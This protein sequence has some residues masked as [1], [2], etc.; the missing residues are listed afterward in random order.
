MKEEKQQTRAHMRTR[1]VANQQPGCDV[2]LIESFN[3]LKRAWISAGGENME[4]ERRGASLWTEWLNASAPKRQFILDDLSAAVRRRQQ[5][6]RWRDNPLFY[7]RDY[8]E[9][10][11]TD[12]NGAR[13]FPDEP[14]VI[15]KHN[16]VGG[17][18]T[19]REAELFKMTDVKPFNL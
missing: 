18:F 13:S 7:L 17:L 4:F 10:E 1:D 6:D 15:A 8:P 9:P 3:A 11:P 5:P 19:A 14:L 12:Y 16:G 2:N